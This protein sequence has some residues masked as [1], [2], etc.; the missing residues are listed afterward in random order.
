[1][2][3]AIILVGCEAASSAIPG[4]PSR[5]VSVCATLRLSIQYLEV[6]EEVQDQI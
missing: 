1:V 5:D 4:M 6:F 3:V 2:W